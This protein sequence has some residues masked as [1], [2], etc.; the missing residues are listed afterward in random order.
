MLDRGV[1]LRSGDTS[2]VVRLRRS[3]FFFIFP[4]FSLGSGVLWTATKWWRGDERTQE[5]PG[6]GLL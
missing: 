4:L 5:L 1:V 3:P 2:D 6:P